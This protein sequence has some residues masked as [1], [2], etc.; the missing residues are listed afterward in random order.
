M[1]NFELRDVEFAAFTL[2]IYA[3]FTCF[4]VPKYSLLTDPPVVIIALF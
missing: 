3:I 1:T 4:A 2:N